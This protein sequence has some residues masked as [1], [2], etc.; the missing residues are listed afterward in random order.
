[1]AVQALTSLN[2]SDSRVTIAAVLQL[3]HVLRN[4]SGKKQ[5]AAIT[6]NPLL[7]ILAKAA[8]VAMPSAILQVRILLR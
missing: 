5:R 1:M 3:P 6:S 8:L 7:G 4:A 2:L